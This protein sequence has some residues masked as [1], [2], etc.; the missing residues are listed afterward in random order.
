MRYLDLEAAFHSLQEKF[1]AIVDNLA[2]YYDGPLTKAFWKC[3]SSPS[4]TIWHLLEPRFF[5]LQS[6]YLVLHEIYPR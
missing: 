4:G 2:A 1:Q 6:T 5:S 3:A